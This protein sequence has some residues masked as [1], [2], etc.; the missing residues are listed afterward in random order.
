M[1]GDFHLWRLRRGEVLA[2]AGALALLVVLLALRWFGTRSGWAALPRFRWSALLTVAA[3][4]A[5]VFLQAAR[6]APAMPAVT[7]V[8]VIVLALVTVALVFVEVVVSPPAGRQ[9][10]AVLGLLAAGAVLLGAFLSLR[11]EGIS[12]RDEPAKIPTVTA[13]GQVPS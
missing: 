7:S 9:P 12:A 8:I 2:F 13:T 6:R 5:L 3:A 10:G 1:K 11:Q 4:F